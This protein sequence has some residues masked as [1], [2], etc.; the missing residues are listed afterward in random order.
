MF[1]GIHQINLD[2]KGRMAMPTR[3]R[4]A[5]H[6]SDAGQLIATIEISVRCVLLFPLQTWERVEK[7][8]QA[9][10]SMNPSARRLQRLM[11]GYATELELDSSGRI[12]LPPPLRDY[13]GLDKE[14]VLVGQG[15]K[16]EIWSGESWKAEAEQATADANSGALVLPEEIQNLVF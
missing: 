5:L 15:S 7:Q 1:R 6:Q 8:I 10:P 14:I 12:L 3:Y 4:D 16:F 13:A 11:L 2:A 9:L